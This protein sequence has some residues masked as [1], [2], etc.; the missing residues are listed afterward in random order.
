MPPHAPSDFQ[1]RNH[2]RKSRH[3][4][5]R[6]IRLKN[7]DQVKLRAELL[8]HG[9]GVFDGFQRSLGEIDRHQHA[10]DFDASRL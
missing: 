10:V 4:R 2:E 5:E 1:F 7:M 3:A 9:Q 6:I 8:E